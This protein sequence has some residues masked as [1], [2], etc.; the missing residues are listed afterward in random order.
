LWKSLVKALGPLGRVI[1]A[2]FVLFGRAVKF[3]WN[4]WKVILDSI[5]KVLGAPFLILSKLFSSQASSAHL[6]WDSDR[7]SVDQRLM[8]GVKHR[9]TFF[10]DEKF[11][12]EVA[13]PDHPESMLEIEEE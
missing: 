1:E 9:E 12:P 13:H 10:G 6:E 3:L 4:I 2:P 7:R 11:R 5:F 8:D